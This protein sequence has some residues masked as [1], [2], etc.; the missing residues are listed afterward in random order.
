VKLGIGNLLR[1]PNKQIIIFFLSIVIGWTVGLRFS[2]PYGTGQWLY[3]LTG[4]LVGLVASF[5]L[6]VAIEGAIAWF[7]R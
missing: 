2:P 3:G 7:E 5:L 4:V 6:L 1:L